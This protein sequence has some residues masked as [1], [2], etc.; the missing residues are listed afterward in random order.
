M[1][2]TI[3]AIIGA[4]L[5]LIIVFSGISICQNLGARLKVD[6]TDQRIYTLCD[7]TK[8]ILGK[9]NQPIK[10]KLYYAES[11]AMKAPD[12]IRYFNSYYEFVKAL[13]REYVAVSTGMVQL[14]IID[15]RPFSQ[16]EEQAMRYGLQRFPITQE[17]NFFFGLVMQ[18]QFGVEKVIPFFSP[19]RHNF[20][21]YDISY[22]IDT[23]ITKQKKKIGIMSSL[24]VMGQDVS[25]YMARMMQM[26]GQQP[27]PPWTIVEQLKNKYEV[28]TVP[29]D[30][31]DINNV[32]ILLVIHPKNL[33]E[34]T[35]FAIDQYVLKGGRT[36][37]CVDPHC[38]MDRP[39]RDPMQMTQQDQSSS[40]DRLMRAWGLEMPKNTFA[41]DR[42]LAIEAP[43]SRSQRAEK[44]IGFLGLT[45]EC[46]NKES[47]ISTNLNQVRLLFAG[48]LNEV[49]P[50]QKAAGGKPAD[51][52]QPTEQKKSGESPQIQRTPLLMTTN[53]G[54]AWRVGSSFEIMF[55]DPA[56]MM[57]NFADGVKPVNMGYLV[58]GRFRSSFPDG[59]EVEVAAK[60]PNTKG[61]AADP[62]K[63]KMVK[64]HIS[65][66]AEARDECAVVVFS[67]VDFI[68]DQLAYASSF[69][70]KMVVGDNSA[71]LLNAIEDLSGSGDLIS[72]RSRGNF[73]RPFIVVDKIEQQAEKETADEIALVNAQI[74]GFNQELQKLVS[75]AKEQDQQEVLGGTIVQK[76]RDLELKIHEAQRQ[77]REIKEK[78]REQTDRLGNT[79]EVV[80]MAAVPSVVM[81]AAVVLG[82]WRSARRRH[83]ISH[84]S[85]A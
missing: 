62:N 17:E 67:D 60:D 43:I 21:E 78:R 77:L 1:S 2:R 52:N 19:D 51:A 16:E 25:G 83:Y 50:P 24:P 56:K 31:N 57:S 44:V 35:Q 36:I 63:P 72:I 84:A 48:V 37:V 28:A 38:W 76:K 81:V 47:V 41:G 18:T 64:K 13:L 12:Q 79:L 34:R 68:S 65:G 22:L 7:G 73:K 49:D 39:Q 9:L 58:T 74:E 80:N 55:P 66:L 23:A 29:T 45:P 69:F 75:S 85:D 5:I 33:P 4:V 27:E 71:L 15:P 30:A 82:V 42:A 53:R 59:I 40:L 20:V 11:A 8:S 54:N 70:G 14:E 6:I 46:F 32:D 3:R 26:Q 10:A 61:K